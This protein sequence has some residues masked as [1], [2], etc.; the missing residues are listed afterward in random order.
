MKN[1]QPVWKLIL[2]LTITCLLLV[3]ILFAYLSWKKPAHI[4]T[5]P[6]SSSTLLTPKSEADYQRVRQELFA[7]EKISAQYQGKIVTLNDALTK[8]YLIN[9]L[10][11]ATYTANNQALRYPEKSDF[12]FNLGQNRLI[13]IGQATANDFA[14]SS[15]YVLYEKDLL[16]E[17]LSFNND[18]FATFLYQLLNRHFAEVKNLSSASVIDQQSERQNNLSLL[19]GQ[20]NSI[21]NYLEKFRLK[22][23]ALQPTWPAQLIVNENSQ[24]STG[25][26]NNAKLIFTFS[27]GETPAKFY[28]SYQP[29]NWLGKNNAGPA[30]NFSENDYQHL[31]ANKQLPATGQAIT[32]ANT[33]GFISHQLVKINQSDSHLMRIAYF[34]FY[35]YYLSLSADLGQMETVD[36]QFISELNRQSIPTEYQATISVFNQLINSLV[37]MDQ[38]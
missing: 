8:N 33:K 23:I 35:Y 1:S 24:L 21:T 29:Y 6:S 36:E 27:P 7:S 32:T 28:L 12:V 34:P 26:P 20:T 10:K 19:G 31:I 11:N 18:D 30:F 15:A 16:S 5:Q 17:Q 37:F 3:I 13:I 14:I 9:I 25:A 2:Q 38:Q 4:Q 22:A